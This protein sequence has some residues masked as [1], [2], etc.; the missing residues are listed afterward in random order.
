MRLQHFVFTLL[1][2]VIFLSCKN[3]NPQESTNNIFKFRKHISY[4][5]SGVVSVT[6]PIRIDLA[7]E[8]DSWVSNEEVSTKSISISPKIE[9]KLSALNSRSLLFQPSNN[10]E[11]NKEYTVT[12]NLGEIYAAI[13]SEFKKYTFKFKTIEQNFSVVTTSFQSYN[14]EWQYIEGEIKTADILELEK[15]KTLIKANQKAKNLAIK[16]ESLDSVSTQFQFKIDSVQRFE[17]DS[18][19]TLSWSGDKINVDNEGES[20]LRIPGKNNFSILSI[21]VFQLP[22]QHLTINF[23]DP[24]KKQQNFNGL[25]EIQTIKI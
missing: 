8:V 6:E 10:L 17:D 24:L 19:V 5:T 18:E 7:N 25:V 4:T 21:D 3:D 13:P 9:G 20:S 12:V 1:V 14:K 11:P 23:S 22:E 15:A 2:S 16:W